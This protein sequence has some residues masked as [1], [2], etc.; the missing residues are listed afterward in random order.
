MP[1]ADARTLPGVE[2]AGLP[3]R[4]GKVKFG[5][6]RPSY[7]DAAPLERYGVPGAEAAYT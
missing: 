6:T 5:E 4:G 1:D 2:V 3:A 7:T